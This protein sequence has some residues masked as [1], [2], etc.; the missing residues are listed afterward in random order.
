MTFSLPRSSCRL[1]VKERKKERGNISGKWEKHA[2]LL[3]MKTIH[4]CLADVIFVG[5]FQDETIL[6]KDELCDKSI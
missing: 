5:A 2:W 3:C 4:V 6:F 1:G